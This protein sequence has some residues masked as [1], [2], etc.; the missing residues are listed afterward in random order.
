MIGAPARICPFPIL[1]E[2]GRIGVFLNPF[3]KSFALFMFYFVLYCLPIR[4]EQ[5]RFV[6]FFRTIK[7]HHHPTKTFCCGLYFPNF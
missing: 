4:V 3:W 5:I 2:E 6:M 7:I 1:Q